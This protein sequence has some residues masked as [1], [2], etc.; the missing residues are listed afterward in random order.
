MAW[1]TVELGMA[2]TGHEG[3]VSWCAPAAGARGGK[4]S[5]YVGTTSPF[6][7]GYSF[8]QSRVGGNTARERESY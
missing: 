3:L 5:A 4:A 8:I 7:M 6:S 1:V 2:F